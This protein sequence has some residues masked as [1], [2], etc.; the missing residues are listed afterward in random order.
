MLEGNDF[1]RVH[2]SHLVN[3][4]FVESYTKGK[5]GHI[6]LADGNQIEVAIRRKEE[7]LKRIT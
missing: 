4:K 6:T 1:F 7:L 2:K 5:G 3:L